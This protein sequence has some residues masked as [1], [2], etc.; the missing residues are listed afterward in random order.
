MQNPVLG[1]ALVVMDDA[2]P[3]NASGADN[4][5]ERLSNIGAIPADI[6]NFLAGF[7]LGEGS[8][9]IVCRPRVDYRR[10]W[11]ISAAF[12]VSQHDVVPLRLFQEHLGCGTIRKAGNEGWYL[13]VNNLREIRSAVIPFFRRF[14]LVGT[15]ARDFELFEAAVS[16][17]G[18]GMHSDKEYRQVLRLRE[19]LNRGGKRRYTMERIL[20]DYTPNLPMDLEG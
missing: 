2:A 18:R 10:G 14:P 5:Q 19:V 12:N 16:I 6:G 17:L 15:K 8:F 9:M 4:Q 13:E 1:T 3:D 11:K 7:A 20:R